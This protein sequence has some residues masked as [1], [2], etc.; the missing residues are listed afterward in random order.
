[1]KSFFMRAPWRGRSLDSQRDDRIDARGPAR[2]DV[3]RDERDREEEQRDRR[4]RPDVGRSDAEQEVGEQP[5]RGDR[6]GEAEAD[7][8]AGQDEPLADHRDDDLARARSEGDPDADLT[9][10]L[11]HG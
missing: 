8:D 1:M 3:A 9:R 11:G 2:R 5:R 4:E 7:A 6:A 10:T